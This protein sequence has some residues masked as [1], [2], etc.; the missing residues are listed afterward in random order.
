MKNMKMQRKKTEDIMKKTLA[1][2]IAVLALAL[3][4]A[5]CNPTGSSTGNTSS[6]NVSSGDAFGALTTI[7]SSGNGN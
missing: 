2:L 4:L 7:V 3:S 1:I 6:G 5:A